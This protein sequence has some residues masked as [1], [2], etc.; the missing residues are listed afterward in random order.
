MLCR[1]RNTPRLGVVDPP[2]ASILFYGSSGD[3]AGTTAE[4][5]EKYSGGMEPPPNRILE[6]EHELEF[7]TIYFHYR[8]LTE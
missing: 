2:A 8:D 6:T 3:E 5:D 7:F 1:C 4:C